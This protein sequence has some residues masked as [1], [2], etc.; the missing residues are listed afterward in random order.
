MIE[1]IDSGTSC[2]PF[3]LLSASRN[4]L[5]REFASSC[6]TETIPL[7]SVPHGHGLYR[8]NIE[9]EFTAK[10]VSGSAPAGRNPLDELFR[11]P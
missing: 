9:E 4:R 5:S 6:I 10:R 1:K 3:L 2:L 7:E 8:D 11:K